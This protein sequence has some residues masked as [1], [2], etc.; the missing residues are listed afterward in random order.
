[1]TERLGEQSLAL[2][3]SSVMTEEQVEVVCRELKAAVGEG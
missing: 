3:F 2:P 1:V